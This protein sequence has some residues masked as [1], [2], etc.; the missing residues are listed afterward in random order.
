M[1]P[2]T[3]YKPSMLTRP[4]ILV[5]IEEAILLL[6][7]LF[8]YQHLHYSWLPFAIL[9]LTPDLFML[10]YL[11][12]ARLGAAVYNLAHTLNLPL[13]LLFISYLKHWQRAPAI[14]LIWTAH[15]AFDRLLGYG[16]KYPTHFKDT[17][18]QHLSET[19]PTL[20]Q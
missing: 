4:A 15:I 16:L 3:P 20:V 14:A 13:A 9:F 17:H 7:T 1:S 2:T 12:N 8:A 19:Q 11:L 10:G 18:L 6:L 5:R